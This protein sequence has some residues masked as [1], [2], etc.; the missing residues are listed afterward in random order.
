MKNKQ[1]IR[2]SQLDLLMNFC[3]WWRSSDMV[4]YLMEWVRT[5][6]YI[7]H[8]SHLPEDMFS[9]QWQRGKRKKKNRNMQSLLSPR[10]GS[11]ILPPLLRSIGKLLW[12]QGTRI[13]KIGT[14]SLLRGTR[15]S[16]QTLWTFQKTFVFS[17]REVCY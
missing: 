6:G 10:L 11:G 3:L 14:T 13:G 12:N 8:V 5:L 16:R 1:E 15:K 2:W 7:P 17:R 9:W 4:Q